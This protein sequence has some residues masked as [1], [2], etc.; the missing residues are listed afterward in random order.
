[1]NMNVYPKKM[2]K[3]LNLTNGLI[4]SQK[5]MLE[6]TNCGFSKEKA[7]RIVQKHAQKSWNHNSSF[8]NSIIGD[9]VIAKQISEAKINKLFDIN[10]HLKQVNFIF[11]RVFS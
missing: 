6:L 3:N 10:H 11:K 4:H 2:I 5:I 9:K 1:M 8:R 7:Y